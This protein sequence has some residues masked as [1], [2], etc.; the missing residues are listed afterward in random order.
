M[1]NTPLIQVFHALGKR[2]RN[3]LCRWV[4][5]PFVNR[6]PEVRRLC[7]YIC[8]LIDKES[9]EENYRKTAIWNQ[10]FPTRAYYDAA[11]RHTM[12]FL[13]LALKQ[14]IAYRE[15]SQD[16]LAV[17]LNLARALRKK[18]LSK[19][20]DKEFKNLGS[21]GASV[22]QSVDFHL[23][24]Y[25][26]EFENWEAGHRTG[27][28]ETGQLT[29]ASAAFGA[30]VAS[31]A[32]RH[33]CAA[34]DK[35]RADFLPE[36][37]DFLPEALAAVTAGRYAGVPAVQMYFHCFL[38]MQTEQ[39]QHFQALKMLLTRHTDLFPPEEIRDV[40]LVAINFCIRRLN[41]GEKT[42]VREAFDLYRSGL[43][44]GIILDNGLLPKATY[45]NIMLL[46]LALDEWEWGRRFLEDFRTALVVGERHN[47]YHFNLALWHF[48]KKEYAQAQDILRRVEFRDVHYN[49]DARRMMVRMYYDT[50]EVAALDSLL[51][52]FR[53]YLQRHRN[54]GYHREL[55]F[56]FVR[57]VHSLI[58]LE[59]G[60]ERARLKL[61]QKIQQEKYLAEREW[62]LDKTGPGSGD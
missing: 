11:L 6:R 1:L 40:Y 62:L 9:P 16:D 4:A 55:N 24:Q 10:I 32:L 23:T 58:Q 19:I 29:L 52:S 50:D 12:S 8:Q 35:S 38:L 37:L 7:E 56:N 15:W 34:L 57:C 22:R 44:R 48:R 20:F 28:T 61:Y 27:Q 13:F 39:E 26:I 18:G 14:W 45:Q 42:F 17:K 54:I 47:A 60:D 31:S 25:Q 2:D 5:S 30:F 41:T 59:P 33:G 3:E 43:E 53:I 49:L 21:A 46:A 51:H 36:N